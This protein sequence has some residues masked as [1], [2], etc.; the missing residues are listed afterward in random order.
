M[1][2]AILSL[3]L[4][5][6][7]CG[8]IAEDPSARDASAPQVEPGTGESSSSSS[9]ALFIDA[10]PPTR[11]TKPADAVCAERDDCNGPGFRPTVESPSSGEC[12]YGVCMCHVDFEL[13]ADGR[14]ERAQPDAGASRCDAGVGECRGPR[15]DGED[16]ARLRV[17]FVCCDE[18][19]A[20]PPTCVCGFET[21]VAPQRPRRKG[22]GPCP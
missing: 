7:A 10:A 4:A 8:R 2:H 20:N 1:R 17:D 16:G 22:D 9:G 14:C 15:R 11:P 3:L 21:C 19:G 6:V 5:A 13:Q 12:F 18:T